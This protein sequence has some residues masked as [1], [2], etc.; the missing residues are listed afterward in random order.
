MKILLLGAGGNAGINFT[1]CLKMSTSEISVVGIDINKFYLDS[2]NA[3]FKEFLHP[4]KDKLAQIKRICEKHHIDMIHAQPDPE[5]RWLLEHKEDFPN[6]IFDH[7]LE[8]LNKFS[9]KLYCQKKWNLI[10][11]VESYSFLECCLDPT[12]FVKMRERGSGK[13]WIRAKSGAGSKAALPVTT[14]QQA[15]NWVN[16]W[17][18]ARGML[19]SEFM[20]TEFLPGKEYAVQMFYHKGKL[21]HSQARQRLIY[22][23]GAL[24]P[25]GQTS[26]PAVAKVVSEQRVY[27]VAEAA[28]RL[29]D[30]NPHGIYCL[31]MKENSNSQ[32]V[33]TEVNY[34]RFFTTSDFFAKAGVNTPEEYVF[35]FVLRENYVP[36]VM[37][38][39]INPHYYWIR[40][41]DKEPKLIKYE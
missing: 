22:F 31:D 9:D 18:E 23:F 38:D 17:E 11:P 28:V 32:L 6:I 13:V 29:I 30:P 21:I 24:M 12:L 25:S 2:S 39:Y 4:D 35:S 37:K 20:M 41:L 16:Y 10:T 40:G 8:M 27:D 3:D 5:V 15:E 36:S 1:K 7:D 14:F 26:T 19:E 33:P 34:G